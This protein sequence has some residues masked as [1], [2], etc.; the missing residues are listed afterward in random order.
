[1]EIDFA[2]TP[3]RCQKFYCNFFASKNE[4]ALKARNS[5]K[6]ASWSLNE[7]RAV[8]VLFYVPTPLRA[9]SSLSRV[10]ESVK[11]KWKEWWLYSNKKIESCGWTWVYVTKVKWRLRWA[12]TWNIGTFSAHWIRSL[13]NSQCAFILIAC[14]YMYI[15]MN[16]QQEHVG[17]LY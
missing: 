12:K 6:I 11:R 3:F 7:G 8:V 10:I 2:L 14:K 13:S 17:D 4:W 1:M 5:S 16:K 9:L 15:C